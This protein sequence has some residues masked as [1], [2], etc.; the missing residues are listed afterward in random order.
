MKKSFTLIELLVVIA[1]IA[2]LASMLLPALSKAREKAR[3]AQ[4]MSN[5][6][7]I[8]LGA[9]LYA[10]DSDGYSPPVRA[11][12]TVDGNLVR[13]W[14][15][16]A[17]YCLPG[18]PITEAE[19]QRQ[20][21]CWDTRLPEQRQRAT[22]AH[23]LMHC[24]SH[25]AEQ[26]L[27]GNLGYVANVCSG[28]S[29]GHWTSSGKAKWENGFPLN[30][31]N[32]DVDADWKKWGLIPK[33]ALYLCYMDGTMENNVWTGNQFIH[34]DIIN[35]DAT[36]WIGFFRHNNKLN[37]SFG[38][39][40]VAPIDASERNTRFNCYRKQENDYIWFPRSQWGWANI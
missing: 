6:K 10:D 39:G 37:M 19:W 33:P 31:N 26:R 16:T 7:S 14:W 4:C 34:P 8:I 18:G 30:N 27:W 17:N 21:P 13:Y 38:D 15:F 35:Y 3:A 36:S 12:Y 28:Y 22:P 5:L 29:H 20:D 23:K 32:W 24:P 2:I 25:R 40:H 1:I 11:D 9:I